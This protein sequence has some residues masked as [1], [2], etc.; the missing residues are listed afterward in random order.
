MKAA[1]V[2]FAALLVSGC[3]CEPGAASCGGSC[4]D[5]TTETAHCGACGRR[6]GRGQL[7]IGGVCRGENLTGT[8]CAT[9]AQCDDRR[10]CNGP[11]RCVNGT[12]RRGQPLECDDG[13]RCTVETCQEPGI[14]VSVPDDA[15]CSGGRRCTGLGTEGCGT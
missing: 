10:G 12:C 11:E 9:D 6:C 3:I 1:V 4:V 2:A 5:L 13:V 8:V 15:Q 14:C 7:C